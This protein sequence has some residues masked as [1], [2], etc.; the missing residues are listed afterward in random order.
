LDFVP[1]RSCHLAPPARRRRLRQ[2]SDL[3]RDPFGGD[4]K[5]RGGQVA[6]LGEVVPGVFE[7]RGEAIKYDPDN[8]LRRNNDVLPTG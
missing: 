7:R 4:A 8:F 3:L 5:L 6:E 1:R 2:C